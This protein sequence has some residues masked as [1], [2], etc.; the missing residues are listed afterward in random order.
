MAGAPGD[1]AVSG[2]AS[3]FGSGDGIGLA[4]GAV[5]GTAAGVEDEPV[6]EDGELAVPALFGTI[7]APDG[8]ATTDGFAPGGRKAAA[9]PP[10]TC[11]PITPAPGAVGNAATAALPPFAPLGGEAIPGSLPPAAACN[12]STIVGG[13]GA[14]TARTPPGVPATLGVPVTLGM[15]VTP[16][17]P[18]TLGTPSAPG[19]LSAPGAP[20]APGVPAT[21]AGPVTPATLG[22]FANKTGAG[23]APSIGCG[24][25]IAAGTEACPKS[26]SKASRSTRNFNSRFLI[27]SC[28]VRRSS[29]AASNRCRVR[30]RC[31]RNSANRAS[32]AATTCVSVGKADDA[33]AA[34]AAA[35]GPAVAG[36]EPVGVPADGAPADGAPADGAPAEGAPAEGAPADGVVAGVA[37]GAPVGVPVG[38]VEGKLE[39][40]VV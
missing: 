31:S 7:D 17:M 38:E 16:G 26:R 29:I 4:N 24:D 15:P 1:D 21:P 36:T 19:A 12:I 35:A 13:G 22:R 34:D 39:D 10:D 18:V 6:P 25:A 9:A 40:E 2:L 8:G 23:A 11:G 33:D 20:S 37:V 27:A 5:K 14:G 32:A 28:D 3:G 30:S